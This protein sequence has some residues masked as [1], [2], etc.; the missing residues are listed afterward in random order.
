MSAA[1]A[2]RRK[3]KALKAASRGAEPVSSRLSALLDGDSVDESTVYEALQLAQSQV[4]RYVKLSQYENATEAAY[5]VSL[6]LLE[7]HGRVSVASQLMTELVK[8]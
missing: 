3:Q 4:R 5:S 8:A 2:R 7:N 1:A 6:K